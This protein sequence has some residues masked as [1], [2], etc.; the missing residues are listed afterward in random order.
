MGRPSP[1]WGTWT[2]GASAGAG[3]GAGGYGGGFA[4]GSGASLESL[5]LES[6]VF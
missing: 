5:N 3:A 1:P 4:G 2:G 6:L